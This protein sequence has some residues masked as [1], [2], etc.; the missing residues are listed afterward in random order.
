MDDITL[1]SLPVHCTFRVRDPKQF[2]MDHRS[3]NPPSTPGNRRLP[4]HS[5]GLALY[6]SALRPSELRF[7]PPPQIPALLPGPKCGR[8]IAPPCAHCVTRRDLQMGRDNFTGR[9][10]KS[11]FEASHFLF[12][13]HLFSICHV[14]FCGHLWPPTGWFSPTSSHATLRSQSRPDW[15]YLN[16]HTLFPNSPPRRFQGVC[17]FDIFPLFAQAANGC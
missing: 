15:R 14:A 16:F 1:K 4:E 3:P 11:P 17:C 9:V 8:G 5:A 12:S 13:L 2:R 10:Q 7:R 6:R